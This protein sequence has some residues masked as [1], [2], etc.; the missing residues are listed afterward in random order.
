LHIPLLRKHDFIHLLSLVHFENR[1]TYGAGE[2]LPIGHLKLKV[3]FARID[4]RIHKSGFL[5][6]HKLKVNRM[7]KPFSDSDD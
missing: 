7:L 2:D 5:M 3:L 1:I 6:S 4:P